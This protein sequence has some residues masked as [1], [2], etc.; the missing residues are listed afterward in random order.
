MGVVDVSP[1]GFQS[2]VLWGPTPGVLDV[3]TKPFPSQVEAGSCEFLSDFMAL[4]QGL[5]VGFQW[6]CVSAFP[7]HFNKGIFSFA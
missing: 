1:V 2:N 5:G 3:G 4:Y 6:D 7:T